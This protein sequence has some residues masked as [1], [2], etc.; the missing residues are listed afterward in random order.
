VTR[1]RQAAHVTRARQAAHV[2]RARQAAH[3]TRARQSAHVT[4]ARQAAGPRTLGGP[5]GPAAGAGRGGMRSGGAGGGSG[6]G[7]SALEAE[8][9]G[10][11]GGPGSDGPRSNQS[12]QQVTRKRPCGTV[13]SGRSGSVGVGGR[14][15]GGDGAAGER[16][17]REWMAGTAGTALG[18]ARSAGS[19]A[20]HSP[21]S[22]RAPSL[23]PHPRAPT[24]R[25]AGRCLLVRAAPLPARV[26]TPAG[27]CCGHVLMRAWG[28]GGAR[29]ACALAPHSRRT[30]AALAPP[31]SACAAGV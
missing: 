13:V 24:D 17:E 29:S 22:P 31:D 2:T 7:M 23:G 16:R 12:Q 15:L 8:L 30:R 25:R 6:T 1:A 5:A 28:P 3:V 27:T 4:R 14:L 26:V 18:A 10:L 21:S 20:A 9:L 11:T 19:T